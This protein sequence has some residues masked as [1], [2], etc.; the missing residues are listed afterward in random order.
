MVEPRW[1]V[2]LLYNFKST[3]ILNKNSGDVLSAMN[4][5]LDIICQ[6]YVAIKVV[7]VGSPHGEVVNEGAMVAPQIPRALHQVMA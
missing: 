5:G 6:A 7:G 2:V 1:K 4:Q 3:R